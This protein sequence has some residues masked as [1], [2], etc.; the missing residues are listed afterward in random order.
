MNYLQNLYVQASIMLV[1]LVFISSCT[2]PKKETE[3]NKS[4]IETVM[5]SDKGIFRGLDLGMSKDSV[6]AHEKI[7]PVQNSTAQLNYEYTIDSTATYAI[8][9][10]FDEKG[11]LSEVQCAVYLIKD[12]S[13]IDKTY[14]ELESYYNE[15]YGESLTDKGLTTWGVKSDQYGEIKINI[16]QESPLLSASE[17]AHGKISIWIYPSF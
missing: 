2:D 17:L 7:E 15:F 10:S 13:F 11:A 8:T 12:I 5:L 1:S 6:L 4:I 3:T 14:A 9:Y 16:S